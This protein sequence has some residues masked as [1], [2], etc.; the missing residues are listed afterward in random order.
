MNW[1]NYI[2][3][4]PVGVIVTAFMGGL[5]ILAI[6]FYTVCIDWGKGQSWFSDFPE[7]TFDFFKT[8]AGIK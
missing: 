3:R 4:V 1:I 8:I 6:T 7:E 2:F 5:N